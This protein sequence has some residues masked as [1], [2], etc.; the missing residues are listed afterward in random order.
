MT[1]AEGAIVAALDRIKMNEDIEL[2]HR[3]MAGQA[4]A[5]GLMRGSRSLS[6]LTEEE[7]GAFHD[8]YLELLAR[9]ARGPEDA[10]PDARPVHL[11][12][13]AVPAE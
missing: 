13:F 11:R 10:S 1:E 4:D 9:F 3:Y 7:L 12:W 6:H 8:A 5:A 2:A